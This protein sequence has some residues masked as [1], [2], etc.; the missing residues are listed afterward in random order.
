MRCST[1]PQPLLWLLLASTAST[2]QVLD[3][4]SFGH[5]EPI[6][7]NGKAI[8]GWSATSSNHHIQFLSDRVVLTPPVPGNARG[9]LWS[10]NPI[11]SETWD[12]EI[13]FRAS[14]QEG[15]SGN[16]QF[17]FAKDK[18]AIN[19]DSVYTTGPFDGLAL[20]IDQ[21]G[22]RGGIVRGFLNDG[23]QNFRAHPSLE[24][25]AFGHCDYSYRNLGRPST[26]KVTNQNGLRVSMDGRECFNSEQIV[27]PSG[28]YFG[29]TAA[30]ADQPD[31]FEIYKFIVN[32]SPQGGAPPPP[33]PPQQQQQQQQQQQGRPQLERLD[34]LPGAPEAVPDRMADDIKNQQEQFADLHNRLQGLTHQIANLFGEFEQLG[35][36]QEERHAQLLSSMPGGFPSDKIDNLGRRIENMERTLDQVKRDVEGK[37]YKE[38]LNQLN[39]AIENVRGGLSDSLDPENIGRIMR[40]HGPRLGMFAFA[41]VAVQV[42]MAG[43]YIIYKRRRNSMPKKYL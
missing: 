32:S 19:V 38:H 24:T 29:L 4:L 10:E 6:A 5:K 26:L 31:S 3:E 7:P 22:G 18:N 34:R 23:Q 1:L 12:A 33:P 17:W 40:T 20:V 15:G 27:L 28:Y 36:K 41:V 13:S 11:N 43:G 25:L 35:R 37:D 8:P 16:L 2:Q 39:V 14:G 30:T 9:A 42:L 21:Y